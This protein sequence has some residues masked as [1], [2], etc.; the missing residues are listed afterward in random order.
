MTMCTT[1]ARTKKQHG[2]AACP[3]ACPALHCAAR[4]ERPPPALDLHS[5]VPASQQYQLAVHVHVHPAQRLY[6]AVIVFHPARHPWS[7]IYQTY[8][9]WPKKQSGSKRRPMPV[10]VMQCNIPSILP[11]TQHSTLNSQPPNPSPQTSPCAPESPPSSSPRAPRAPPPSQTA[12]AA[13]PP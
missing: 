2:P 7:Y 4:C 6:M 12:A 13:A 5:R 9:T 11:N 1:T 10:P 8:Y 3:A